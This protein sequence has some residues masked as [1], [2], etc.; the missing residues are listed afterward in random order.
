MAS[1]T[2]ATN[3]MLGGEEV[4]DWHHL[5][6]WDKLAGLAEQYVRKGDPLWVEGQI[7][8][9]TSGEEEEKRYWTEIAVSNVIFL[10]TGRED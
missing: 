4:A 7:R 9:S 1:L 5:T 2:L 3:R 8:Y 10:R 6:F